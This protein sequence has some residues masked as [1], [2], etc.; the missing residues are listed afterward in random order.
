MSQP[1]IETSPTPG[2]PGAADQGRGWTAMAQQATR[3][4]L[5]VDGAA[6]LLVL[7]ALGF[8]YWPTLVDLV[9]T[10]RKNPDY[11][12][13]FLVLPISAMI[14]ARLWPDDRADGPRVFW[15]GLLLVALGLILRAF[16]Q[17]RGNFWT[18]NAT[19]LV[20]VA[21]VAL[22]LLGP[23]TIRF[24]WPALA[25]LIFLLPLPTSINNSL[26]QPL[27]ALA[28][29]AST[30]V[31]RASGLWVMPEGNVILVGREPLE[32]AEACNG[33]SMLMSLAATV[34][35]AAA[36]IPMATFKRIALLVSIIPVALLSNVVRI[37]AT[38]WA[39]HLW[40]A[41]VG[42]EYAHDLAGL[43][44]MPLAMALV[45]LELWILSWLVI[46]TAV[47]APSAY[48]FGPGLDGV[49]RPIR[50]GAQ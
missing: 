3:W 39:Y 26:S 23:R 20:T 44:M 41:K 8:A 35:A 13:G 4:L 5:T 10:W 37:S 25:F 2:S 38:A 46:E 11:S 43:L 12:H 9:G 7:A 30:L 14:G 34:A 28:T 50:G 19:L 27:Q 32:V 48:A 36:L 49:G 15:P 22:S 17:S 6:V 29:R 18:T 45:G 42:S 31:L 40:G 47:A 33:L 1:L 16:F 21:G 24:I